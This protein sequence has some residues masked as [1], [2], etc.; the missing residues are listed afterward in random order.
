MASGKNN[1][2]IVGIV[3][4]VVAVLLALYFLLASHGAP[5]GAG[6][7]AI[8]S[9]TGNL[10][11]TVSQNTGSGWAVASV[12]FVPSGTAY[13]NGVPLVNWNESV[14]LPNGFPSGKNVVVTLRASGSV[15]LGTPLSGTVWSEWQYNAGGTI[16][17]TE[18]GTVNTAAT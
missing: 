6:L 16:Y 3:I 12:L 14:P 15:A 18:V 7:A 5:S 17:Y 1:T 11:V 4:V 13:S 10:T 8:Y 2:K 9:T